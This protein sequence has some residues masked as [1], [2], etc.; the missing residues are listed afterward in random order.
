MGGLSP[1]TKV[2]ECLRETLFRGRGRTRSPPWISLSY[3]IVSSI[4]GA[5][6]GGVG[7]QQKSDVHTF[8]IPILVALVLGKRGS[9]NSLLHSW[10]VFQVGTDT[11]LPRLLLAS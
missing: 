3:S 2:R 8:L 7:K 5:L 11:S 4:L 9:E 10:A 6:R 1:V